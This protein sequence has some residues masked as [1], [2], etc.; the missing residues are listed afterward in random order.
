M[1]SSGQSAIVTRR[2]SAA[3]A[4]LLAIFFGPL[5]MLYVRRF[6]RSTGQLF[7]LMLPV[8]ALHGESAESDPAVAALGAALVAWRLFV[9]PVWAVK[10]VRAMNREL[11]GAQAESL[12]TG[13]EIPDRPETAACMTQPT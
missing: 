6:L 7:L 12:Q 10:R 5:G 4:A 3:A 13:P 11:L 2:K 1:N 9:L 8:A